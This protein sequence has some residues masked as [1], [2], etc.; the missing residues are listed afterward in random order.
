MQ[1]RGTIKELGKGR[2]WIVFRFHQFSS[3]AWFHYTPASGR[4]FATKPNES[5][6]GG[7]YWEQSPIDPSELPTEDCLYTV[8]LI[9][10]R[11]INTL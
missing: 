9:D 7:D 10:F 4:I 5:R 2:R 11:S 8:D 6:I 3:S 1:T